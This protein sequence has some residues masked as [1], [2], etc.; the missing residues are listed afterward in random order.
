LQSHNNG[1]VDKTWSC[2]VK[3]AVPG[4]ATFSEGFKTEESC[5]Q[6]RKTGFLFSQWYHFPCKNDHLPRQARD[7]YN[8]SRLKRGRFPQYNALKIVRH[9]FKWTPTGALADDYERKLLNGVLGIQVRK[10]ARLLLFS[11]NIQNVSTFCDDHLMMK[12]V[13][14]PRQARDKRK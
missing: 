12:N 10:N 13:D 8:G 3:P 11:H 5:T 7:K 2:W 14:L 9:L 6:V 1:P 4:S